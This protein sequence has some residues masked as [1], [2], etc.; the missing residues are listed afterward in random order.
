MMNS[1]SKQPSSNGAGGWRS[2]SSGS[3][4]RPVGEPAVPALMPE[5]FYPQSIFPEARSVI[6]IGLPVH[7]P[8]LETTLSIYY[9]EL[10]KTVNTLLDQYNLPARLIPQRLRI[11]FGLRPPGRLRVHRGA[12]EEPYCLLF[13]TGTRLTLR[14]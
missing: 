5:E 11:P 13:P 2:R 1:D 8:V 4:H 14:G 3:Q 9:H 6:V 12:P 7:L 10:Y